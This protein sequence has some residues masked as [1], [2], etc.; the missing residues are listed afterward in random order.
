[1]IGHPFSTLLIRA[2][3]AVYAWQIGLISVSLINCETRTPGKCETPW[4]EA[5][6]AAGAI[7]ATLLAWLTD[8]PLPKS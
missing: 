2:V 5:R 8:S 1:M 6:G 4:A 3:L 7:P